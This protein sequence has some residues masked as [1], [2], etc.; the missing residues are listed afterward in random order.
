MTGTAS[1]TFRE[2]R[3]LP[4]LHSGKDGHCQH[5]IQ[6]MTGTA[7]TTF[8]ERR[9]LP[10][11]HSGNDG[12]CQYYIQG[13]TG[14]AS[15]TFRERRALPALHSGKDGHCQQHFQVQY[16]F[17]DHAR[18]TLQS[19]DGP[20]ERKEHVGLTFR[21]S[22]AQTHSSLPFCLRHSRSLPAFKTGFK[23]RLFK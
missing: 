17:T 2:R 5:Y 7:S 14:T 4:A 13:M 6:G 23:T 16:Q 12:H 9:A 8:R 11:L 10:A 1:T 3:A 21:F 18:Y 22:A 20:L 19:D 15:T